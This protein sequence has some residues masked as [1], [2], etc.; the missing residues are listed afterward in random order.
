MKEIEILQ[1]ASEDSTP[2]STVDRSGRKSVRVDESG[3]W[4]SISWLFTS[5]ILHS[6]GIGLYI[7]ALRVQ[8]IVD[9]SYQ[10]EEYLMRSESLPGLTFMAGYL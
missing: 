10:I 3:P 2:P 6:L 9:A 1:G 7:V 5:L 8:G 4:F